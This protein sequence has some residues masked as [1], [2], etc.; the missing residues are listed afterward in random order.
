MLNVAGNVVFG[1]RLAMLKCAVKKNMRPPVSEIR[2]KV[3]LTK[4]ED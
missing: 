2:D 3:L 1:A 4:F